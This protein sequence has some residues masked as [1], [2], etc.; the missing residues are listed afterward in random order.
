M[1]LRQANVSETLDSAIR[2]KSAAAVNACL[3][4]ELECCT[5]S[6]QGSSRA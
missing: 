2:W 5:G 3:V 1:G 6:L 4:E